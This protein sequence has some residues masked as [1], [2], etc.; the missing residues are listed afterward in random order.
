MEIEKKGLTISPPPRYTINN[1]WKLLYV[2]V[3]RITSVLTP[4]CSEWIMY[5]EFDESARLH[6]HGIFHVKDKIKYY[7]TINRLRKHG[8]IKIENRITPKWEEYIRKSLSHTLEVFTPDCAEYIPF[9][10]GTLRE[11]VIQESNR[12]QFKAIEHENDITHWLDQ[13]E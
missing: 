12:D 8:F 3:K 13:L 4:F 11:M 7:K 2:W 5:P 6:F 10:K 1:D 9:H